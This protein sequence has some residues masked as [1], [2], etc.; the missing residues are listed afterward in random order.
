MSR[1]TSQKSLKRTKLQVNMILPIYTRRWWYFSLRILGKYGRINAGA[2]IYGRRF[3][4]FPGREVVPMVTYSELF[5][6][7][8]VLIGV[9]TLV[10]QICK[11]K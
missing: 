5:A 1:Y 3:V 7:S 9:A 8:L 2:A 10:F 11:R 4:H 6:Y